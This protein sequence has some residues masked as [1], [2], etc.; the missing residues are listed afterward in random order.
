MFGVICKKMP[1]EAASS[2]PCGYSLEWNAGEVRVRVEIWLVIKCF[3]PCVC[4]KQT[5]V[6][7]KGDKLDKDLLCCQR[8][9]FL[10]KEPVRTFLLTF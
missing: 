4:L 3:L 8:I 2:F 6:L 7:K 10:S 1:P 5:N 9:M